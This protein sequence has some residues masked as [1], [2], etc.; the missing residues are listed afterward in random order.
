MIDAAEVISFDVFDTLLLRIV[1]TPETVF[2]CLGDYFGMDNFKTFRINMQTKASEKILEDMG[3]PHPTLDQIYDYIKSAD[4]DVYHNLDINWDEVKAAEMQMEKD[5]LKANTEIKAIYDY[6]VAQGKRVIATSDMYLEADFLEEVL[7]ENGYVFSA[8]YDSANI[9]KTKWVGDLYEHVLEAEGVSAA[10]VVHIGDNEASDYEVAKRYG[11]NSYRYVSESQQFE[12]AT[13]YNVCVGYGALRCVCNETD[14]FWQRLGARVGGPL[15]LG[16]MQWIVEKLSCKKYDMVYF[17]SRDGYNLYHLFK[18]Y[19]D[20]PV[21]YMYTSRRAMLLASITELDDESLKLL[22][23]FIPGQT[24]R[25]ALDVIGV[26]D[27]YEDVISKMGY[28]SLDDKIP[29]EDERTGRF[30]ELYK[31]KE[32]EFLDVCKKERE[33]AEKYLKNIGFYDKDSVVFDCGWN[34]SSQ[35]LLDRVLESTGYNKKDSFLYAGILDTDLSRRQLSKKDFE[36]YLFDYDSN[37]LFQTR[38]QVDI[39]LLELFFG[40]PEKTINKYVDGEAVFDESDEAA[41]NKEEMLSGIMSFMKYAYEFVSKYKLEVSLNSAF[42]EFLRF[43]EK[44]TLDEAVQVGDLPTGDSFTKREGVDAR[45]GFITREQFDEG[46]NITRFWVQGFLR[47]EDVDIELKKLVCHL[48]GFDIRE[49]VDLDEEEEENLSDEQRMFLEDSKKAAYESRPYT[50][51]YEHYYKNTK[52]YIKQSYE[53]LISV[54][55]PVYNVI[56]SQLVECIESILSQTYTNWELYLVD[57]NSSWESV[58]EVLRRYEDN[59]KIN[60]IY[61]SENGNISVATNDGIF[62]AKGEFIAFIDC[63]DFIEPCSFAEMVYYLNENPETD[64]VYS[65]ED[66]VSEEGHDFHNPFFKPD[67]SPD[68]ILSVMYTNHLAIYRRSIVCEVG[69]LRK[70][71]DGTQDYDFTL[72]FMEKSDNKR[73][74]H[75]PKVLYHWRE[76]PE[77]I[78]TSMEAKPYALDAMRRL[79]EDMLR[80]RN[81]S[82]SVEFLSDLYQYSINYDTP[83]NPMVSIVIPSKD[84]EIILRQCIDSIRKYT[85]YENYEIVVVDNGSSEFNKEKISR[86]ASENNVNYVYEPM[87]FNFS[88]MC[89]IG[90]SHARGEYVLL[91]NDD[92]EI[93]KKD[94]LRRLLGQA[95]QSHT[96]CVGAKLLYPNSNFIQHVGV[97]NL[98]IGPCHMLMRFP[99]S[100][101]YSF[102]RNRLTYNWLAVTGAC[103][104]VSKDK[105]NEVGGLDENLAVAYNDV[106]F[107]FKLYEAGYY[108][109][110]R[111]DVSLYHH[112]SYSRG[113]DFASKEKMERLK[114][115]RNLLYTKHKELFGKDPFHSPNYELGH[116]DYPI[117]MYGIGVHSYDVKV[118]DDVYPSV[119][120]SMCLQVDA[121]NKDDMVRI[122]GW[123]FTDDSMK[124]LKSE[125]YILLRNKAKQVYSFPVEKLP[126]DD[127]SSQFGIDNRSEGF[128]CNIDRKLLATN[129]YDYEIGICQKNE[130]G[131]T[132][133]VWS[134]KHVPHDGIEDITYLYYSR[135]VSLDEMSHREDI[136]TNIDDMTIDTLCVTRYGAFDDMTRIRGWAHM[137]GSSSID[138]R[139]E[140]GVIEGDD[141]KMTLY[142][143]LRTP[144]FDVAN[145][146]VT[147]NSYLSGF[148][149]ELPVKVNKD[150]KLYAVITNMK[151]SKMYY[152][153]IAIG[154]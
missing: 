46:I 150:T 82:G 151:D 134:D 66:K 45:L 122:V 91:L 18:K 75:V 27:I 111:M 152:R 98:S 49:Y 58:R 29:E 54:V 48:K 22:P 89:N 145:A 30:K 94:W 16:L 96:G 73:V 12:N 43:V 14:D 123:A 80:R 7:R 20:I 124:D 8:I 1:N 33:A 15:Y 109:V 148:E 78:A 26:T 4:S 53:P 113:F 120:T 104:L 128:A 19:T 108:N 132:D 135:E 154:Y 84:N 10:H 72:R 147:D 34:G 25:D 153:E 61:R 2:S 92:V 101:T 44:P 21:C 143:T 35:Y 60:I 23:P 117:N 24:I 126:R 115:E 99:D 118:E 51:W 114:R 121:V 97:S 57:D 63:D 62:S 41:P 52:D 133:Y 102:G 136:A 40:S 67:W 90:A 139:I 149:A 68:T 103:L 138:N 112:E 105:Y 6:A 131:S 79:K 31:L 36:A 86:Y 28:E 93:I 5:V 110:S 130:D 39:R 76:R 125:R 65:D 81:I 17:M 70:E 106:D 59:P 11:I 137:M 55:I 116:I 95:M 119:P 144:R 142:D 129:F 38:V 88:R 127:I 9:H 141:N 71:Y 85:D 13:D 69:G 107:C 140:I 87:D 3:W 37:H 32:K 56:E 146:I 42:S 74:G 100:V 77:S 50:K 47:R 83:G 64:F